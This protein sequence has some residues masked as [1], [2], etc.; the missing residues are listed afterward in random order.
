MSKKMKLKNG[1]GKNKLAKISLGILVVVAFFITT[2]VLVGESRLGELKWVNVAQG[3]VE[4]GD[5]SEA[6]NQAASNAAAANNAAGD[7]GFS[8]SINQSEGNLSAAAA[9]TGTGSLPSGDSYGSST[10]GNNNPGSDGVGGMGGGTDGAGSDGCFP[11]YSCQVVTCIGA[12]CQDSACGWVLNG[13]SNLA[14]CSGTP[15]SQSD[16]TGN[17]NGDSG[18]SGDTNNDNSNSCTDDCSCAENLTVEEHCHNACGDKCDGK[19]PVSSSSGSGSGS[20]S[21]SSSD[22]DSDSGSESGS[23][24]EAKS[25][26]IKFYPDSVTTGE[27]SY[28]SWYTTGTAKSAGLF[29]KLAGTIY[30]TEALKVSPSGILPWPTSAPGTEACWLYLDSDAEC[31]SN[32]LIISSAETPAD[33]PET[34][35]SPDTNAGTEKIECYF[36]PASVRLGQSSTFYWDATE[37]ITSANVKCSGIAGYEIA[38]TPLD[39]LKG[40]IPNVFVNS[41][42]TETCTCTGNLS[43]GSAVMNKATLT[44]SEGT[45]EAGEIKCS[46]V[47]NSIKVGESTKLSWEATGVDSLK[48]DCKGIAGYEIKTELPELKSAQDLVFSSSGTE[49]CTFTGYV[50]D[51]A[52]ASCEATLTVADSGTSPSCTVDFSKDWVDYSENLN[53]SIKV[54]NT[55]A[56]KEAKLVCRYFDPTEGAV[57][58]GVNN[59]D[60]QVI[61]DFL[62]YIQSNATNNVTNLNYSYKYGEE[63]T[64]NWESCELY[65]NASDVNPGTALLACLE[66]GNTEDCY[67]GIRCYDGV[68]IGPQCGS[69]QNAY[70]VGGENGCPTEGMSNWRDPITCSQLKA[71]S[72]SDM[73]E[74]AVGFSAGDNCEAVFSFHTCDPS[75]YYAWWCQDD[76]GHQSQQCTT[77]YWEGDDS[78]GRTPDPGLTPEPIPNLPTGPDCASKTCVGNPCN[79]EDTTAENPWIHGTKTEGCATGTA[80]ANPSSVKPAAVDNQ[81]KAGEI[82]YI[83]WDST[84]ASKMEAACTG[85]VEIARGGWYLNTAEWQA[86]YTKPNAS[87]PDGYPAW[88]HPG[89]TDTEICTFYPTN[90]SNNLPGTPFS[91][92]I[93][94][95]GNAVCGNNIQETGEEC[96]YTSSAGLNSYVP[97][98]T[99]KTCEDCACVVTTTNAN[100]TKANSYVC[101]PDDSGCAKNTC[102]DVRCFD[103]CNYQQGTKDC[104]GRE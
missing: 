103:G 13:T 73:C 101:Q 28:F 75:Y 38:E 64:K 86:T 74:H 34:D 18:S 71:K 1:L 27:E 61:T 33:P 35:S 21:G 79:S 84:N 17:T 3:E 62:P 96:D 12:T 19:N 60:G 57:I 29:C 88:F 47:E 100:R 9:N 91:V 52:S 49:K 15:V 102:K 23:S 54:N 2:K 77:G 81:P 46:F 8:S 76:T 95:L 4:G 63:R 36:S 25:C 22:S 56:V 40:E 66:S 80:S 7:G 26:Y 14:G 92:S 45:G 65:L 68:D 42:G 11:D 30:V 55:S 69:Y 37:G 89:S 90:K 83:T 72:I 24:D 50:G 82:A 43:D 104:K 48:V 58:E 70:D 6:G 99:G 85:P 39:G 5:S 59:E 67:P 10:G 51:V 93:K 20:G 98:P 31:A 41:V 78:S 44:V 16:N 97:C 32:E 53:L 94:L 87:D